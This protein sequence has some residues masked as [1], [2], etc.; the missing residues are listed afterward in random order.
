MICIAVAT[1]LGSG[2]IVLIIDPLPLAQRAA[3]D[4]VRAPRLRPSDAP[5]AMGAVVEMAAPSSA[6]PA[7]QPEQGLRTQHIVMV[8]DDSLTVRRV[9]QRFLARVGFQVVLAKDGVVVLVL[10]LVFLFVVLL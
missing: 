6:A 8:V 4:N 7:S 3:Q 10:L 5:N 2:D 9:P 1:V